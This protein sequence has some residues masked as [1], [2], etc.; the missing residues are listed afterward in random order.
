[1]YILFPFDPVILIKEEEEKNTRKKETPPETYSVLNTFIR[2]PVIKLRKPA[3]IIKCFNSLFF[4]DVS[5]LIIL[6]R[7]GEFQIDL[8]FLTITET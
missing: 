8:I 6:N 7:K 2:P 5:Y 1:M 4:R 3:S